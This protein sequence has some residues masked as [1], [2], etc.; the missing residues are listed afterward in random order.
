MI[1]VTKIF[2][3]LMS[4]AIQ[5]ATP[6]ITTQLINFDKIQGDTLWLTIVLTDK[7]HLAH[8]QR[9]NIATYWQRS[10]SKARNNLHYQGTLSI[11]DTD[12]YHSAK[13]WFSLFIWFAIVDLL[14]KQ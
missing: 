5:I 13:F 1:I 3:Y 8:L 12:I 9:C 10:N 14:G 11:L 7:C 4:N 2:I 6:K